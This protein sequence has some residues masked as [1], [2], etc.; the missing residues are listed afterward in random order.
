M[1]Y[2]IIAYSEDFVSFLLEKID[3]NGDKIKQ[4]ILFGSV[5]RGESNKDSDIDLFIDV[6]DKKLEKEIND[7]KERFYESIKVKKYWSLLGVKNEINCSVGKLEEWDNLQRSLIANGIVLYGKYKKDTKTESY[8]LFII[9]PGKDRNKNISIWRE[10]YGY[11]QKI[12]KKKY[13]KK[14]LVRDYN[15]KKLAKGVFIIP[16]EHTQKISLFLK[17]NKFKYELIS[18]WKE[19]E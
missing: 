19:K 4:I 3:K 12:N 10:L 2:K 5:A 18:F 11:T 6:L 8:Y 13:E 7:I 1:N 17:K 9:T 14:G 16:S 15:G